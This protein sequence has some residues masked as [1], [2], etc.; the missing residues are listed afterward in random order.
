MMML[1][2][3]LLKFQFLIYTDCFLF[4][5]LNLRTFKFLTF[6]STKPNSVF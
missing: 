5:F 2:N 1:V 4:F 6:L 3:N